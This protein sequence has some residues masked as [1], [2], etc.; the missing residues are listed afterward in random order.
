L[1]ALGADAAMCLDGGMSSGLY[2]GGRTWL[3]PRR[4]LTNLLVVY[5]SPARYQQ[6][7]GRLNPPGAALALGPAGRE[8]G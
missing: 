1:Q 3:K 8:P 2:G 5:D 6:V 7:A 4:A